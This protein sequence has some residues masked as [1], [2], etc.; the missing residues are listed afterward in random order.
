MSHC[1]Y[2]VFFS[3]T[4]PKPSISMNR[5]GQ[6]DWGHNVSI[7]CSISSE[8]LG[9]TFILKKTPGL[10]KA[11]EKSS[12][13]STTFNILEVNF[14]DE[15][16]Y[17]CQFKKSIFKHP[18]TSPLSDSVAGKKNRTSFQNLMFYLFVKW[19]VSKKAKSQKKIVDCFSELHS[20][21]R[22]SQLIWTDF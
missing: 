14:D 10:I 9:G 19:I 20:Q 7:T 16:S 6:I 22:C 11:S 3:V 21:K 4:L 18:F 1:S 5:V 8:F 12:T 2:C 15:G 13:N 17:Q